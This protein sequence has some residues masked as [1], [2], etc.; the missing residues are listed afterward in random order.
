MEAPPPRTRPRVPGVLTHGLKRVEKGD[1][2]R[3]KGGGRL[4]VDVASDVEEEGDV[5]VGVGPGGG[6]PPQ[7][8]LARRGG[9]EGRAGVWEIRRGREYTDRSCEVHLRRVSATPGKQLT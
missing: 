2:V 1:G 8:R 9:L 6:P 5:R 7:P 3:E 4:R